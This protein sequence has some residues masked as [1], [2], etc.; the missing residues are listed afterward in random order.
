L[1]EKTIAVNT[2]MSMACIGMASRA[3]SHQL[4]QVTAAIAIAEAA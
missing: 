1:V 2:A 3:S 4:R